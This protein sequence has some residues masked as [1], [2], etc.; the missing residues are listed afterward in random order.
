M[1]SPSNWEP[2]LL[3]DLAVIGSGESPPPV[4]GLEVVMG[5][6]GPIGTTNRTNFGPGY[7]V[8]R[9]GAAGVVNYVQAPCWA[10]D[11]TLTVIPRKEI[12]DEAFLGHLLAFLRPERLATKNA[13][14]LITQTNLG[15]LTSL[16]PRQLPEQ[17]HIAAILDTLDE[18][19]RWTEQVIAKLQQAK[20]GLLHDLLT[21]G[22]D[23]NGDLRSPFSEVP[24]LYRD[25]PLGRIPRGWEVAKLS[26]RFAVKG[27]KRLPAGH[28]YSG[29]PTVF[30]YLRVLDFFERRV[31]FSELQYLTDST[32]NALQHYEIVEP[33]LFISIAGSLGFVGVY[34]PP[35]QLVHRTILTENAAK[36]VALTDARP[37]FVALQ[38]NHSRV[39]RQIE[40]EKG[41]GGG[42]PKLALFR[43]ENLRLVWPPR[44]EQQRIEVIAEA[45]ETQVR[46]EMRYL[47]KRRTLS[48]GLLHDLLTGRV[49]VPMSM[50]A[51][52]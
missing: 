26:S 19:I 11:N 43:I 36:L 7:L 18:A 46:E 5:A 14:P 1:S 45:A 28:S 17:R 42:V 40:I 21:R 35:R 50:G 34:R 41:T 10:S 12:C 4:P 32:F 38:M 9:V 39:Q 51:P 30:R 29:V 48:H 6:N 25:S 8:G 33:D 3:N 15:L 52:A 27:G 2:L 23:E 16:V 20:Q 22:V 31:A 49:R 13:Q 47:G 24:R 37:E 44:D